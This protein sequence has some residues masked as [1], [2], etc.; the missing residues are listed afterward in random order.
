MRGFGL[1]TCECLPLEYCGLSD[2]AVAEQRVAALTHYLGGHSDSVCLHQA[3]G[4][5][6]EIS[7]TLEGKSRNL[8]SHGK[9]KHR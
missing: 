9:E 2:R 8:G 7:L 6:I 1:V 4:T 5:R 3:A